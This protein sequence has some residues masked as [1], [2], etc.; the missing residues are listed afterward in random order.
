MSNKDAKVKFFC[1]RQ[2]TIEKQKETDADIL[3]ELSCIV[4]RLHLRGVITLDDL[5]RF[6]RAPVTDQ[7]KYLGQ[8]LESS[9]HAKAYCEFLE[10]LHCCGEKLNEVPHETELKDV[11][12]NEDDIP[13][14]SFH[15]ELC[16]G[17]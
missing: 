13:A 6:R 12:R 9:K 17:K 14:C 3:K 15:P 10:A 7:L 1:F 2:R 5:S 11:K 4:D 16:E 8:L